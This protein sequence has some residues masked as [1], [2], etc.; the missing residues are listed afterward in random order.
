MQTNYLGNQLLIAM[1]SLQDQNFS[2]SVTFLCKHNA[3]GAFG[4]VINRPSDMSIGDIFSDQISRQN[5]QSV[6]IG[7][8]IHQDR[9]FVLHQPIGQWQSTLHITETLGM[10][11]SSDILIAIADK[12]RLAPEHSLVSIGYAGW[13]AGQLEQEIAENSWLTCPASPDL[14]FDTP[15]D[16][17]WLQAAQTLG[18][19]LTLIS[20]HAGHA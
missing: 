4:L 13:A 16:M 11:V 2:H 1:P 18:I 20:T 10:T 15:A 19:D 5:P 8:P 7:G 9:G 17:V 3:D 6:Y 12:H 14:L